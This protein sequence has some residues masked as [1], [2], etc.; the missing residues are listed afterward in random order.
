MPLWIQDIAS[1]LP[2]YYVIAL[3]V[4][5]I[6]GTLDESQLHRGILMQ[7]FWLVAAFLLFRFTWHKALRSY[8][9]VGS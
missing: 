5:L 7:C 3:P 6:I 9:A 2:F 4:E 1:I 8:S